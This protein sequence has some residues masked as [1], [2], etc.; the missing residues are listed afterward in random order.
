MGDMKTS[1][2]SFH[3]L[4]IRQDEQ[5]VTAPNQEVVA[6]TQADND[7]L[8]HDVT[9]ATYSHESVV[10]LPDGTLVTARKARADELAEKTVV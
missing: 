3:T 1:V 4:T 6:V 10:R 7:G 2:V 9:I 5:V 8:W